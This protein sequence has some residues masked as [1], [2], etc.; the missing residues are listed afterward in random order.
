MGFTNVGFNAADLVEAGSHELRE[1]IKKM[2]KLPVLWP[3]EDR[4]DAT[5]NLLTRL[6]EEAQKR[7]VD[8]VTLVHSDSTIVSKK[9]EAERSRVRRQRPKLAKQMSEE[10][11]DVL[12]GELALSDAECAELIDQLTKAAH[13]SSK[14]SLFINLCAV[15]S[16]KDYGLISELMNVGKDGLYRIANK[17]KRKLE[18]VLPDVAESL[19]E[20]YEHPVQ[21]SPGEG[22]VWRRFSGRVV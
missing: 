22:G 9:F 10:M 18:A 7:G 21:P 12:P 8:L 3:I 15:L 19:L 2:G 17:V 20:N 4:E 14:E 5:Q 6:L 11:A 13:L 1:K 16:A